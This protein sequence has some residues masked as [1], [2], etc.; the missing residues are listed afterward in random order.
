MPCLARCVDLLSNEI[1]SNG[2]H[3]AHTNIGRPG[4]QSTM[5]LQH[6]TTTTASSGSIGGARAEPMW[7][8]DW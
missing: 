4:L 5:H 6:A 8:G 1:F 7:R 3:G 2:T